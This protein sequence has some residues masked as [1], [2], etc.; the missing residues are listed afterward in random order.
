[1]E[2]HTGKKKFE[3]N[4]CSATFTQKM[5]LKNHV[6]L[7]VTKIKPQENLSKSPPDAKH[8]ATQIKVKTK[9]LIISQTYIPNFLLQT[10]TETSILN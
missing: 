7:H 6:I 8:A 2:K 10:E 4:V 9:F 3:C 5:H 1:M